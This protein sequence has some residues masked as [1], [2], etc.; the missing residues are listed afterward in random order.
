MCENLQTSAR[1]QGCRGAIEQLLSSHFT[2]D[3]RDTVFIL[4][5]YLSY[6]IS[7]VSARDSS[8]RK[9]QS[10]Y[11]LHSHHRKNI[12]RCVIRMQSCPR[13]FFPER[14]L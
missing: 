9:R 13:E 12:A 5:R 10:D 2:S 6:I 3:A 11:V 1:I 4:M 7:D 14:G 8:R